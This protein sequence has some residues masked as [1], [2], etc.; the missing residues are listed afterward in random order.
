MDLQTKRAKLSPGKFY[1]V[2]TRGNNKETIFKESKNYPY[3]LSR[4]K[5]YITPIADIYSYCLLPNHFHF[6]LKIKA[7]DDL[8]QAYQT[9]RKHLS[10]PFAICL[11]A[12]A[13]AINKAHGRTGS[14]FEETYNRVEITTETY[15]IR[16]IAYI[17]ANPQHHGI[18]TDFRD[19]PYSS[20]HAFLSDK[21]TSLM[22]EA[23]WAY[24]GGKEGFIDYHN[25]HQNWRRL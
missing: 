22:R 19:Y 6:C 9:G 18:C 7:I 3:F 10:H 11:S 24:F 2:F 23:V 8:P 15:F 13:K 20:F 17:H 12:Y 21:Q 1:H 5:Q 4:W 16:L 25:D 14:L